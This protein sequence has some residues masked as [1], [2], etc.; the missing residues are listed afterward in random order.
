MKFKISLQRIGKLFRTER[1]KAMKQINTLLLL[2]TVVVL[3]A[4]NNNPDF[5]NLQLASTEWKRE[6]Q[7]ED[8]KDTILRIELTFGATT[9][10]QEGFYVGKESNQILGYSFRE[11]GTYQIIGEEL[12]LL[13]TA[14][15]YIPNQLYG[16]FSEL[17]EAERFVPKQKFGLEF[18]TEKT[19]LILRTI[20][21][22]PNA[23]CVD[24]LEYWKD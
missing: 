11:E 15:K 24:M 21:C 22:P 8:N 14:Q 6:H 4:C 17:E 9:F 23:S 18:S 7:V 10:T 2:I 1:K 3:S 5:D 12:H 16:D 20:D 13:Y 19:L